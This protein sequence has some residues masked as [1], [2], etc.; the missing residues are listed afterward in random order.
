MKSIQTKILLS[1]AVTVSVALVILGGVSIFLNVT[2]TNA[3][4]E[5]TMAQTTV[6]AAERVAQELKA[7]KNVAIEVGC[8]A[9]LTNPDISVADKQ[10]LI[11]QR[12]AD[13]G[14]M[15]GNV[16]GKDGISIFTGVDYNDR[17]YFKT[18]MAGQSVVSE[19]LIAKTTGELS[20]IIAAP[21]WKDGL[22]STTVE[23]V[24]F[25]VPKETFLNDI[26]STIR[27]S[28]NGG[29]YMINKNGDT[30]AHQNIDNVKNKENTISDAQSDP[31]LADL[32]EMETRLTHGESGFGQYTYGGVTKFLSYAPVSGTDGWGIGINAPVSDFTA[33]MVT[34]A[35]VTLI[36]LGASI[37]VASLIGVLVSRKITKPIRACAQR[38]N[39]LV[40]G[41]LSSPV[42]TTTAKDETG[43]LLNDLG[44]TVMSMQ[45]MIGDVAHHLTE[46]ANGNLTLEVTKQYPGDFAPLHQ[47]TSKILGGLNHT[48]QQI[49]Q[50]SDEVSSGSD[51]VSS[52]AQALSQGSTEQASSVEELASTINE[53]AEQV[54]VNAENARQA[55]AQSQQASDKVE[56]SN[57][58]MQSMISAISE[59]SSK[60][61]E[62]GKIIKTIED[63]AFQTNILALNAAVEAARAGAAGKGFAVVADEVRNLA[64]KSAEAAKNTTAL[65]EQNVQAVHNGTTIAH[66]AANAMDSIMLD[67]QQ[68]SQ[69]IEQITKAS[70]DQA[71]AL[72]Q[73]T[74]GIDQISSVV[75]TNSAT[76]E[77]SAAASEELSSQAQML[78]KMVGQFR[79]KDVP[80]SIATQQ[81]APPP[82]AHH[83]R[84]ALPHGEISSA[85]D[86]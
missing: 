6:V 55:S 79:L 34:S 56:Q 46:I 10:T 20:I 36:L 63:I 18:A 64:S 21:L 44:H 2:S 27:I 29:T 67:T 78:R 32:A 50:A 3:T 43:M 70:V 52:G 4:L 77:Q 35:I 84:R 9:R 17:D 86:Y 80:Q 25:F 60:S 14:F 62:I 41:D 59:I 39:G 42:P 8:I 61:D 69:R 45:E 33:S 65:I 31:Q 74:T 51:Q 47:S 38:L 82:A 54:Q 76:A 30:I 28:P 83:D 13:H 66:E 7:Y 53:I 57:V 85:Q 26:V 71:T 11:D 16:I 19:P 81:F 1:I 68:V 58:K 15:R 24:V 72:S 40:G 12:A 22:T 23:G 49:N 5:Q 48:L 75:Q 73:V 37:V